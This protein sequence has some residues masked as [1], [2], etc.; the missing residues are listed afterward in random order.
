[1]NDTSS[2][3]QLMSEEINKLLCAKFAEGF[4]AGIKQAEAIVKGHDALVA[5]LKETLA[6]LKTEGIDAEW[7]DTCAKAVLALKASG[8]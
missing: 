5:A 6:I 4:D 8:E 3:E 1:M 2:P 7:N